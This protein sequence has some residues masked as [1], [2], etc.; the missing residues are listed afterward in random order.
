MKKQCYFA[1]IGTFTYM[2]AKEVRGGVSPSSFK[3]LPS[4]GSNSDTTL[5]QSGS[6]FIALHSREKWGNPYHSH[7][8]WWATEYT[9]ASFV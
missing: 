5:F 9:N 8:E 3:G 6:S 1:F 4:L 2:E 7:V